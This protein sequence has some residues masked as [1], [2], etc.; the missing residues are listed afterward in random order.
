M[1]VSDEAGVPVEADVEYQFVMPNPQAEDMLRG[2]LVNADFPLATAA[3]TS[4]GSYEGFV[5]PGP[6]AVLVTAR[7]RTGY[8]PA[9][10]DPKSFFAPG[11]TD[12][13]NQELISAYGTHDTLIVGIGGSWIDQNNYSA[14][15]LVN[16]PVDSKPMELSA[17]LSRDKRRMA[18]IVDPDGKPVIGVQTN[19]LTSHPWDHEP[20]LRASTIPITQL[21]LDRGRRITFLKE[22]RGLIGFLLARGDGDAP[23]T[24]RMQPWATVTGRILNELGFPFSGYDS[25]AKAGRPPVAISMD[26]RSM[27][28]NEDD[29]LYGE[30]PDSGLDGKSRFRIE[31]LIPGQ[32]YRALIYRDG[33]QFAGVAFESVVL[34]PG[35]VR[36]LGDIRSKAPVDAQGK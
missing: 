10:V 12:W 3:R 26:R 25:S 2:S 11:K 34:A 13:T 24:V 29:P 22:D 8:R 27:V 35:E 4:E 21:R 16:P 20:P 36:D 19:G 31:R 23:Y 7:R 33:G 9:H 30:L 32:R 5:L 15:L 17:V 18:T 6:G 14:I 28:A 1:K